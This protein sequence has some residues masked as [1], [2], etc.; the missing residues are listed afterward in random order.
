[1]T[2]SSQANGP[3]SPKLVNSRTATS[4][5][6]QVTGRTRQSV[7]RLQAEPSVGLGAATSEF[8]QITGCTIKVQLGK[9]TAPSEVRPVTGHT[10]QFQSGHAPH[11]LTLLKSRITPWESSSQVPDSP[12]ESS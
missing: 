11:R 6:S 5:P 1:M 12:S 2:E 10:V 8:D 9:W 7:G 3:H 4:R